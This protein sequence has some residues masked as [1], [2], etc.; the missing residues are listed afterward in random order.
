VGV[1]PAILGCAVGGGPAVLGAVLGT[2]CLGLGVVSG[3]GSSAGSAA[4]IVTGGII[5]VPSLLALGPCSALGATAGEAIGASTAQREVWPALL[6]GVPGTLLAVASTAAL[7]G[8]LSSGTS[9]NALVFAGVI[10]DLVAAPL[11]IA[12]VALADAALGA[13]VGK[14]HSATV[15]VMNSEPARPM[16]F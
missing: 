8:G 3:F 10:G 4:L 15:V 5:V 6:G 14:A 9:T 1:L 2:G 13:P 11:A 12:G 7:I 16:R